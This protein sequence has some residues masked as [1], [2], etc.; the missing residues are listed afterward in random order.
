MSRLLQWFYLGLRNTERHLRLWRVLLRLC[1]M[2][3]QFILWKR[4]DVTEWTDLNIGDHVVLVKQDAETGETITREGDL[5][6]DLS[7]RTDLEDWLFLGRKSVRLLAHE[8][9]TIQ[10]HT[11]A[12][13]P[14]RGDP[15]RARSGDPGVALGTFRGDTYVIYL[16]AASVLTVDLWDSQGEAPVEGTYPKP[17]SPQGAGAIAGLKYALRVRT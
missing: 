7:G 13:P 8:G 1:K 10:T 17:T 4:P 14:A 2:V 12:V 11:G 6:G 16:D 3:L 15:A 9:Y 5:T